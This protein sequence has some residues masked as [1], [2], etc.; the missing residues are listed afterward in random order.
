VVQLLKLCGY[1]QVLTRSSRRPSCNVMLDYLML[2]FSPWTAPYDPPRGHQLQVSV[3]GL[4]HGSTRDD[5]IDCGDASGEGAVERQHS[6]SGQCEQDVTESG[7]ASAAAQTRHS[8]CKR[9]V[10]AASAQSSCPVPVKAMPR[11]SLRPCHQPL[12]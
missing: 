2:A 12:Y 11:R 5:D 9:G 7:S 3:A 6:G 1:L 4:G 10:D 8:G